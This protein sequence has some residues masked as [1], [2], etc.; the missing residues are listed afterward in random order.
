MHFHSLQVSEYT[1]QIKNKSDRLMDF[2]LAGYFAGGLMLAF[3][4]DTWLVAIGVGGL[5]LIAYYST[6]ILLRDSN[7]YQYVLSAVLAIFMAQYI[8][9]MHGLFEM[10]FVAFI[11]SA[12][13]ITHQN[14]KLQ[15]P[16]AL[17]VVVHH[18]AF[19]Y[20]QFTGFDQIYFTELEYMS[21]QTF[22]I[23]AVLAS[24]IFYICGLWAYQFKKYSSMHISQSFEIGRLQIA[25]AQKEELK[26]ANSE[27][28]NFVYSVSHDLRAPLSSMKGVIQIVEE[29]TQEELTQVHMKLLHG[30]I[31]KL[32]RFILD[33]LDYSRN[34]RLEVKKE[35]INFKEMLT[36]ITDNLKYMTGNNRIIDIH[37]E[38]NDSKTFSSDKT[39]LGVVLNNLVSNAIRYQNQ[40]IEN[41]FVKIK[42][43]TSDTEANI[44]VKDNGIGISKEVHEKIFDMFYRVSENSVGSGLGLY[45]TKETVAKLDGNIKVKSALGEGT[46]FHI[47]LPNC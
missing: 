41:P 6:K 28:D 38:V 15:L 36:E 19:G 39:R 1:R 33:I 45:L 22:I 10:H 25:E 37:I 31:N 21:L 27:L 26:K 32:D 43:D 20:L 7:L 4:F 5:S 24:S 11:G 8:Y 34:S 17:L 35:K 3:F 13:L 44:V 30:S 23:H 12:I 2:F 18:A 40:Q 47:V 9:Q 42:I 14:W 46:E 29:D 16:L